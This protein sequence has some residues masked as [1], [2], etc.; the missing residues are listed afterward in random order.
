MKGRKPKGN[1]DRAKEPSFMNRETPAI[2]IRMKGVL[3][4]CSQNITDE[5][6]RANTTLL[7]SVA[8]NMNARVE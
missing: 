5:Q 3:G 4:P 6:L 7:S 1:M 2:W 8:H